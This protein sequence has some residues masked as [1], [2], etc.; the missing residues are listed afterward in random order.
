MKRTFLLAAVSV[1]PVLL[2]AAGVARATDSITTST[3][4]PVATATATSGGPDNI[5]VAT[6]GAVSPTA[7]GVAVTLN[8]NNTVS[9]EG[10]VS[11]TGVD[12]ATAI[13]VVGGHAGTVTNSSTI[14]VSD[15][16]SPTDSNIDGLI[17]GAFATGTNRIGIRVVGPGGFTGGISNLGTITVHG[18][19]SRG[20]SIEAPITGGFQSVLVTPA[21]GSTAASIATGS[22]SI[23]GDNSIGFSVTPT[24]SV[25]GSV[26]FTTVAATG[27]NAK[28]VEIDGAVGGGVT[29][30]GAVTTTGYRS[31]TRSN[32][33]TLANLYT[34][35][36]LSTGGAAVTIGASVGQGVMVSAPPLAVSTTNLDVDNNGV[37]DSLQGAGSITSYGSAPALLIGASGTHVELGLV[38]AGRGVVGE[39]G[40]G[41]YG[42]VIQGQV[43][44]NGVFDQLT[45]PH[46]AAPAPGTAIQVGVSGGGSTV[47]DGGLYNTGTIEGQA[48]QANATAIHFLAGASTPL[49][50]NDGTLTANSTQVNS[51]TSGVTPVAVNGILIDAGANVAS[52]VNNSGITANITGTGGVGGT[53]GAII[54]RSGSLASITNTGSITA[55]LTQTLVSAPMPGTLTAIDLSAG[56]GPQIIQQAVSPNVS[57]LKGYDST[58]SY[59]Q[60]VQVTY[61]GLVYQ[62]TTAVSVSIDPLNYPSYWRQIGAVT[63]SITGSVYFGSGGSTLDVAAGTV[64]GDVIQ[65]GAGVNTIRVHG[66]AGSGVTG[67]VVTGS[68]RE[69]PVGGG[70]NSTLTISVDNGTLSDT[71]P[72]II[73]AKS[74]T[75]GANGL[76]L[77]SA[78]PANGTNTTFVTSGA[79]SFAQ[80]AQVGLTLRSLPTALTQ[81]YTILKT[82]PGQGTLTAGT[83][84]TGLLDNAPFLFTANAA[85]APAAD[86]S[87]QSSQIL[88]TVSRKS[89]A[90][91][92]FNAAEGA[93]LD[94]VLAAAPKS[95]AIQAALLG[96]TSQVGLKGVYDQLLPNQ[97]QGLFDSLD[98]AVRAISSLTG[99]VPNP[100]ARV[101]GSNLWLQE[102]NERVKRRGVST[103]GSFSKLLGLVGGY[104]VMG[105]GGGAAG[106]TL[107]YFNASEMDTASPIGAGVQS[108]TVEVGGY[109]RREAGHLAASVRLGAGYSWLQDRRKFLTTGASILAESNWGALFVDGHAQ[110]G[111]EQHLGRFYARPEL[112]ADFLIF[113]EGSHNETGGADGFNL[114]VRSRNNSRVSGQGVMVFGREWG[115][116]SAWVRTEIRGGFREILAGTVGDTTASFGGGNPFTLAAENDRGGWAT[117][118]FSIKSGSQYSYLALEGDADFRAGERR[119]DLRIA[120]RSLF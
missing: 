27:V 28:G 108:S 17:D 106:L 48:Y 56:L 45:T 104:E 63:P 52:I 38:G 115:T 105:S 92:G 71:N 35:Q 65:L 55:E 74:V 68:V 85:F 78:D 82:V 30:S 91:L 89:A 47:I 46:L 66:A 43:S 88:L 79:S 101:A 13:Q 42:L 51:A 110:V 26:T 54:D 23:V 93:A 119:Y 1:A 44:G 69:G 41:A 24:G 112:S 94:A 95:A 81:T 76:L 103:E 60:G 117:F 97:G 113:D 118:G 29:F 57:S 2:M 72:N 107:A 75:V 40:A 25:G 14:S 22:I 20:V 80:G 49:I 6:G 21:S 31:T 83:F 86:P 59:A 36:E 61:N 5:D 7:P 70:G 100:S 33:P 96:Q 32:Y 50:L 3:T 120:G 37:P 99:T 64:A 18:N 16:Y 4:T 98:A 114:N 62:A 19:A 87:T 102:V 8:S 90:Q 39:G 34:A 10:Q 11:F 84:A 15:S 116:P 73:T 67:A 77:V 12:N 109:Y 9:V 58:V 53:A 111:Y